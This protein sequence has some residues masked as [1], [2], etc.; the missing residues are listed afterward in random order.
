MR[1]TLPG[2]SLSK[3]LQVLQAATGK[4][5]LP[6][7]SGF[8]LEADGRGLAV[9]AHNLAIGALTDLEATVA[10]PGGVVLPAAS[11]AAL[12]RHIDSD[13]TIETSGKAAQISWATGSAMLPVIQADEY[14]RPPFTETTFTVPREIFQRAVQHVSYAAA[15][16]KD[17]DLTP[18]TA[19]I[20]TV[21]IALQPSGIVTFATNRA[22][23]ASYRE[24]VETG[25]GAETILFPASALAVLSKLASQTETLE[26]GL[27]QAGITVRL[28][29]TLFYSRIID[30][31]YP[32]IIGLLPKVY[33]V[34]VVTSLPALA[35]ATERAAA[36]WDGGTNDVFNLKG[37]GD[38][39]TVSLSSTGFSET[40]EAKVSANFESHFNPDLF[41]RNLRQVPGETVELD[42]V[43]SRSI[44]RMREPGG[45]NF[46]AFVMPVMVPGEAA[47]PPFEATGG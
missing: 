38:K 27:S 25:T 16:E 15:D 40:L 6:V 12:V 44:L 46:A 26:F 36:L 34:T 22:E 21:R 30:G 31:T 33:P 3:A 42:L 45:G 24:Q 2:P 20:Q 43:D 8:L 32:S 10:D 23:I 29:R 4:T 18:D 17:P 13:I 14:P 1:V 7:L 37:E 19:I 41:E 35:A 39:L 28:G 9:T 47:A 5:T 11:L